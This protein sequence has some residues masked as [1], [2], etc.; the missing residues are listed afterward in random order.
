M[1]YIGAMKKQLDLSGVGLPF[2]INADGLLERGR[3]LMDS[4]HEL[5][6]TESNW[7]N[8]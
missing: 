6:G 7:S 4:V 2:D 1:Q 3:Q 5:K 8:F